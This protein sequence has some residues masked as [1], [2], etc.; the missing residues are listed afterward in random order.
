MPSSLEIFRESCEARAI[1]VARGEMELREA[2]DDLQCLAEGYGLVAEFGQDTVQQIMQQV[3]LE[4]FNGGAADD[5]TEERLEGHIARERKRLLRTSSPNLLSRLAADIT[6][7]KIEWYWIGR[8]A[9]GKHTCLGGEPGTGKSQVT[10]DITATVT[11]G[12]KWPCDEGTA[13]RGSV[14]ILSAED[15]AADTIVPRLMAAGAD[16]ER[17]HIISAVCQIDGKGRRSFNLQTDIELL[18]AKIAEVGDVALVI[19]DPVSSYLGKTDS[20]K[21]SEVRGV[22]EPLGEMGERKRVGVLSVTHFNKGANFTRALHKFI[23]SVA[24]VGA[25]RIAFAVIE[26]AEN[27]GRV[28]V[29]HAKNNL[30]APPKGLAY[31][32][33]QTIIGDGIP[34]SHVLWDLE[35]VSITA[36]EALAAEAGAAGNR[37]AG[38]EAREFLRDILADGPVPQKEIEDAA[39][40]NGLAWATVRRA[41]DR[42]HVKAQ[43]QSEGATGSGRWVWVLQDAQEDQDAHL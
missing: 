7:E 4:V 30:A 23:G 43:R 10:I 19:I 34:A 42:L 12:G 40:G 2:T 36:T 29:L 31:R 11:R 1:L 18:E 25:P 13:P 20:H 27:E 38:D 14:I 28:L 26:D 17:V 6:P 3:M 32:I 22:L 37:T 35:P 24:F 41:K 16:L 5:G 9:R 8:L 15:S 33:A 21:N 39:E